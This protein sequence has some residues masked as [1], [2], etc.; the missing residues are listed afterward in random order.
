MTESVPGGRAV[1]VVGLRLLACWDCG[2]EFPWAWLSASCE[3][4]VLSGRSLGFGPITHL[5]ESC[6]VWCVLVRPIGC[7]SNP[8]IILIINL[9]ISVVI[10]TVWINLKIILPTYTEEVET[11]QNKK[12]RKNNPHTRGELKESIRHAVLM[13]S[14]HELQRVFNN[15]FT[16]CQACMRIEVCHLHHLF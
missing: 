4:C 5:H 1:L 15:L 11:N 12:G 10:T 14:E 9:I 16:K 3:C 13:I 2:F 8:I 6:R 7:N